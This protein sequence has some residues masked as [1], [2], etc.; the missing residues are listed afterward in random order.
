VS[1]FNALFLSS[2]ISENI[3]V[4]HTPKKLD[5]W[6][7]FLTPT[8]Y[9]SISLTILTQLARKATEVGKITQNNGYYAEQGHSRS[10]PFGSNKKLTCNFLLV[11]NSTNTAHLAVQ[12]LILCVS[13]YVCYNMSIFNQSIYLFHNS[14]TLQSSTSIT[15][16]HYAV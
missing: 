3:I 14:L 13:P 5:F 6:D 15:A 10:P 16:L 4:N 11:N 7:T 1:L 12:S 8:V 9:R 2:L